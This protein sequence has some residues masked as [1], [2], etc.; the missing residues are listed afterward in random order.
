MAR[1]CALNPDIDYSPV[2]HALQ[3][4]DEYEN[5][6]DIGGV[7][8][9]ISIFAKPYRPPPLEEEATV[10]S[11]ELMD[12]DVRGILCLMQI[13]VDWHM[14]LS[15]WRVRMTLRGRPVLAFFDG[16]K[17]H[18][19]KAF[20]GYLFDHGHAPTTQWLQYMAEHYNG[21]NQIWNGQDFGGSDGTE[22]RPGTPGQLE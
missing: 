17:P 3:V 4:M 11:Y 14:G 2:K 13:R 12:P 6:R 5:G 16:G 21:E 10:T 15:S 1:L 9:P 8:Y 20:L 22:H 19:W 18:L 7:R